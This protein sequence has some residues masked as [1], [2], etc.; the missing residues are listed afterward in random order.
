[1]RLPEVLRSQMSAAARFLAVAAICAAASS[2]LGRDAAHSSKV[3]ELSFSAASGDHNLLQ[4]TSVLTRVADAVPSPLLGPP[5]DNL[6]PLAAVLAHIDPRRSDKSQDATLAT[7]AGAQAGDSHDVATEQDTPDADIRGVVREEIA[8]AIGPLKGGGIVDPIL[9]EVQ[10]IRDMV[11]RVKDDRDA[12]EDGVKRVAE[13]VK[14]VSQFREEIKSE[15]EAT[16]KEA[17]TGLSQLREAVHE[18]SQIAQNMYA[19]S[20]GGE[21][22]DVVPED[23]VTS[24]KSSSPTTSGGL[25]S[26]TPQLN[27]SSPMLVLPEVPGSVAQWRPQADVSVAGAATMDAVQPEGAP[28][29]LTSTS[30]AD[31]RS[32]V[33]EEIQ[34]AIGPLKAGGLA[35]PII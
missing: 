19:S 32:I 16:R 4:A 3:C 15:A 33:R 29:P 10:T 21:P 31:I 11:S 22:G 28:A 6:D 23:I 17:R 26:V 27:L 12:I 5:S 9:G 8:R 25:G 14:Q 1:M 20:A 7:R 35:D 24:S 30:D 13:Q 34:R 18:T 2:D